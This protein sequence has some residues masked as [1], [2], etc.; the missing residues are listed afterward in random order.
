MQD[1][2]ALTAASYKTEMNSMSSYLT[3]FRRYCTV[4]DTMKIAGRLS[5]EDY[6]LYFWVGLP[7]DIRNSILPWIERKVPNHNIASAYDAKL[8]QEACKIHFQ[9]HKFVDGLF[10][11]EEYGEQ[12]PK[13]KPEDSDYASDSDASTEE[14]IIDQKLDSK[15]LRALRR[16][17]K[18]HLQLKDR[19]SHNKSSS[20]KVK[21]VTRQ[22]DGFSGTHEEAEKLRKDL[23][24]IKS[25]DSAYKSKNYQVLLTQVADD[26]HALIKNANEIQQQTQQQMQELKNQVLNQ[27][28]DSSRQPILVLQ[29]PGSNAYKAESYPRLQQGGLY[30]HISGTPPSN[31]CFGC[32]KNDGHRM[33]SCPVL[34]NLQSQGYPVYFDTNQRKWLDR[35]T[36]Q[37]IPKNPTESIKDAILRHYPSQRNNNSRGRVNFV[38][39]KSEDQTGETLF[40]PSGLM[41]TGSPQD[42]DDY[43]SDPDE[44]TPDSEIEND[45]DDSEFESNNE[46]TNAAHSQNYQSD[47]EYDSTEESDNYYENDSGRAYMTQEG[48]ILAAERTQTSIRD[49]RQGSSG[50]IIGTDFRNK[51]A[52]DERREGMSVLERQKAK[53]AQAEVRDQQ[54]SQRREVRESQQAEDDKTRKEQHQKKAYQ[55]PQREASRPRS[56]SVPVTTPAPKNSQSYSP[57]IQDR[58]RT[59]EKPET[60]RDAARRDP[61]KPIPV[62][63]REP[64]KISRPTEEWNQDQ[65]KRV[66]A[67]H[68]TATNISSKPKRTNKLASHSD[69]DKIM[70]Q[71]L[72]SS[73]TL[74]VKD[75]L[76]VSKE[77][78]QRL[79]GMMKN[80]NLSTA[81]PEEARV[82]LMSINPIDSDSEYEVRQRFKKVSKTKQL[83]YVPLLELTVKWN[84]KPIRAILDT[85]SEMNII[86]REVVEEIRPMLPQQLDIG[87]KM[88]SANNI[89]S[90]M[91]AHFQDVPLQIGEIE[92]YANLY[93]MEDS[94][95]QLLL[96][97]PWQV[98]NLVSIDE[99]LKGTTLILKNSA[100]KPIYKMFLETSNQFIPFKK[101]P[102]SFLMRAQQDISSEENNNYLNNSSLKDLVIPN[103]EITTN[104]TPVKKERKKREFISRTNS[105]AMKAREKLQQVT[106]YIVEREDDE[107][108]RFKESDEKNIDQLVTYLL[109]TDGTLVGNMNALPEKYKEMKQPIRH[110]TMTKDWKKI[111]D[112]WTRRNDNTI[113]L[114]HDI[115]NTIEFSD[116]D[117]CRGLGTSVSALSDGLNTISQSLYDEN[118]ENSQDFHVLEVDEELLMLPVVEEFL[119][120]CP[121]VPQELGDEMIM[122]HYVEQ[123][124]CENDPFLEPQCL[125]QKL[126]V[127]PAIPER[128]LSCSVDDWLMSVEPHRESPMSKSVARSPVEEKICENAS[129]DNEEMV[130]DED[131]VTAPLVHPSQRKE[132]RKN[133]LTQKTNDDDNEEWAT[134]ADRTESQPYTYDGNDS[135][136]MPTEGM[137]MANGSP[138]GI[139]DDDEMNEDANNECLQSRISHGFKTINPNDYVPNKSHVPRCPR[140][141]S[142]IMKVGNH[143]MDD[144]PSEI[145]RHQE[146][147]S[148]VNKRQECNTRTDEKT[149]VLTNDQA[150]T[151]PIFEEPMLS[152][153]DDDNDYENECEQR[154]RWTLQHS[155]MEVR[156]QGIEIAIQGLPIQPETRSGV[157]VSE[158]NSS[159]SLDSLIE[160][161][162]EL[163]AETEKEISEKDTV[164][165]PKADKERE[166]MLTHQNAEEYVDISESGDDRST[167]IED[168]ASTYSIIDLSTNWSHNSQAHENE[169][170][171]ESYSDVW[172]QEEMNFDYG[173][174]LMQDDIDEILTN[175]ETMNLDNE[176]DGPWNDLSAWNE[177]DLS[178]KEQATMNS[179]STNLRD[180]LLQL[181]PTAEIVIDWGLKCLSV[182]R[183][184]MTGPIKTEV[185]EPNESNSPVLSDSYSS[186]IPNSHNAID[187]SISIS[188]PFPTMTATD[189]LTSTNSTKQLYTGEAIIQQLRAVRFDYEYLYPLG[190][191]ASFGAFLGNMIES[192]SRTAVQ[193]EVSD[194]GSQVVLKQG[195]T[196]PITI[197]NTAAYQDFQRMDG[198][199]H[200]FSSSQ[201]MSDEILHSLLTLFHNSYDLRLVM[202]GYFGPNLFRVNG[203]D[204]THTN[205]SLE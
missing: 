174:K 176:S 134:E 193:T 182:L 167:F 45:W 88:T 73:V 170:C 2:R 180:Q 189:P 22:V 61:Y 130:G 116:V 162:R 78:R 147:A 157:A 143:S 46:G 47:I 110:R 43:E 166:N 32:G 103:N 12:L 14:D 142:H 67:T 23:N 34:T 35:N 152:P 148:Q 127:F 44:F 25:T 75:V 62:N 203:E 6:N 177:P 66:R 122:E 31:L 105:R 24:K 205:P 101:Q 145:E 17:K 158:L 155:D 165:E 95:F 161:T 82:H 200:A 16:Q 15:Y 11:P 185:S 118:K 123:E 144:I 100:G 96:G 156:E 4:A 42:F 56:T 133:D 190:A 27:G 124:E 69:K 163:M 33:G 53:K 97:R 113:S 21:K 126:Y 192:V 164:H 109:F 137:S 154:T 68:N 188:F 195:V 132:E 93:V 99:D 52:K 107:E 55:P 120:T 37:M 76:G 49:S 128:D 92:T 70:N 38:R 136:M 57:H 184:I 175:T 74:A 104:E 160:N 179:G 39:M 18:N 19:H 111:Y 72:D 201:Q 181:I 112:E 197:L 121:V 91:S 94:P 26:T 81:E 159:K 60:L 186:N 29:R 106:N 169:T 153:L 168:F 87:V 172:N 125:Q 129:L 178:D 64:R 13:E 7:K 194:D 79:N 77:L 187:S 84:D 151:V 89:N 173:D 149:V 98:D 102:V 9:R 10:N 40:T 71:I 3:Y 183:D 50:E 65:D 48:R 5:T 59:V 36:G 8:V 90:Q 146:S 108:Y 63:A 131:A 51:R 150:M 138:A 114:T 140:T 117:T 204:Y 199:Y 196:T 171:T 135:M 141:E 54:R 139:S 198:R 80:Q 20:S 202:S 119:H 115:G 191:P 28:I 85:G 30:D 1:I 41:N 58:P 83:G 86:S